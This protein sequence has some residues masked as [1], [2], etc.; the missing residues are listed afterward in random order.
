MGFVSVSKIL[1][2]THRFSALFPKYCA[3]HASESSECT[4]KG[5]S[6]TNPWHPLRKRPMHRTPLQTVSA[7]KCH[8]KSLLGV[9]SFRATGTEDMLGND[10]K[11]LQ[12][13][14]HSS[15]EGGTDDQCT[16][17]QHLRGHC[18]CAKTHQPASMVWQDGFM[19]K[20]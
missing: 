7:E 11:M 18:S 20:T 10:K 17:Q 3:H 6:S 1:M 2:K 14:I 5:V 9:F 4:Q 13:T 8:G 19:E 15:H 16:Y 12:A